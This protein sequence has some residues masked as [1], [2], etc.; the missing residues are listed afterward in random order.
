MNSDESA[1]LAG[2]TNAS[3]APSAA[4]KR[5]LPLHT[6]ILLGLIVGAV[7]GIAFNPYYQS[8]VAGL[9]P[10][11][12]HWVQELLVWTDA[13]GTIFLRLVF[14]VVLPLVLSALALGV[15]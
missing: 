4:K 5:G 6:K 14:I 11:E 9:A 15:L 7:A 10:K 2:G 13:I 3:S 8:A 12:T 1:P